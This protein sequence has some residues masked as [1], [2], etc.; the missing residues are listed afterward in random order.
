MTASFIG[1]LLGPFGPETCY[2]IV[3]CADSAVPLNDSFG[4]TAAQM[5]A[6]YL[7]LFS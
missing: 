7:S 4:D 2:V 3:N 6:F 1:K 5:F